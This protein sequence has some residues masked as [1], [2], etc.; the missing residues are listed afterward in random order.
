M[1]SQPAKEPKIKQPPSAHYRNGTI[2]QYQYEFAQLT[3]NQKW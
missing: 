1:I 2:E 3:E